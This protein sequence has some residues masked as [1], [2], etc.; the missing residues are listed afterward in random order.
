VIA[1]R[2][3]EAIPG[4][5]VLV[6]FREQQEMIASL[7]FQYVRRGGSCKLREYVRTPED[8]KVPL[9][10]PRVLEY[11]R[12]VGYYRDRF[13]PDR[14]LALPYEAFRSDP[15]S[16]VSSILDFMDA[17]RGQ[18]D[19]LPLGTRVNKRGALT[20]TFMRR[21]LNAHITRPSASLNQRSVDWKFLHPFDRAL[22]AAAKRAPAGLERRLKEAHRQEISDFVGDRFKE[23]N[24]RLEGLLGIDL[25]T[26]GYAT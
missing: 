24:V 4:A 23:S 19:E 15:R 8:R 7:Y 11:D 10:D 9:F 13:G 16:F 17:D 1:D 21:W 2:I 3:R 20:A 26:Y 18:V 6:V 22:A 25:A 12:I 5:H 14:V